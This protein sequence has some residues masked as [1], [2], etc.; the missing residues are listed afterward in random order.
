MIARSPS[1]SVDAPT[2]VV[3]PPF[4]KT[5]ASDPA[6][7]TTLAGE[8]LRA[9][10]GRGDGHD[11]GFEAATAA[12]LADP[13]SSL[14]RYA[15]ACASRDE[16]LATTQLHVLADAKGC[17]EC[18]D[19]LSNVA[20]DTECPWTPAQKALAATVRPSPQRAALDAILAALA[21]PDPGGAKPYFTG[22]H[23]TAAFACTVCTDS[24]QD[25][26]FAGAGPKVLA[27][28]AK[29]I[30]EM[31]EKLMPG[32]RFSH[33]GDCFG[34]DRSLVSHNH[35]YFDGLCFAHGTTNVASIQFSA[36]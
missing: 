36:G 8:A 11:N 17:T 32:T 6:K 2:G 5:A 28:I 33:R 19:D 20:S 34:A 31:G 15:V 7:A 23:V 35:V 9:N 25:R 13:G 10:D 30:G 1:P 3:L 14:A 21:S 27:E 16:A 26:H 22:A 24:S 12:V 18:A 29:S 4:G